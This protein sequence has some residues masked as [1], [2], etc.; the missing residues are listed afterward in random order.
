VGLV[1]GLS[2][3]CVISQFIK[4]WTHIT[5][6]GGR[7]GDREGGRGQDRGG[8]GIEEGSEPDYP[9]NLPVLRPAAD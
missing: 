9:H 6:G 2:S 3:L 1:P 7:R 4:Y 8:G 5:G